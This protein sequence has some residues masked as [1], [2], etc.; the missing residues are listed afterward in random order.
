MTEETTKQ[1]LARYEYVLDAQMQEIDR[2]RAENERL[3]SQADAHTTLRSIY[4]NPASP[5]GNRIKAA[6]AALPVE[7][8]KLLSVVPPIEMVRREAWRIYQRWSLRRQIIRETHGLP[9]KGWDAHL[10][11]DVYVPPEGDDMP[12]VRVIKDPTT[13]GFK[14]LDNLL[15]GAKR[16]GSG[17]GNGGDDSAG[18]K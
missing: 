6:A 12:P 11:D 8:P 16:N 5:E 7:K 1:K 9:V 14:L 3:M 15:P 2:L 17:N 18:E 13:G 4:S 10:Q